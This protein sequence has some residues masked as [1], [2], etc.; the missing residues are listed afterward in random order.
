MVSNDFADS[1]DV[2]V[3]DT[4]RLTTPRGDEVPYGVTGIY[5]S[6]EARGRHRRQ[7]RVAREPAGERRHPFAI[8]TGGE[9]ADPETIKRAPIAAL[10]GFPTAKA[11]T[12]EDFKDEQNHQVD[13]L[14]GLV[15]ALLSLSV[16]V[17]LLGIINTLALS[18]HERTR[19]LGMLRAVGM[20]RRQVRRMVRG[21]SVITAV[22]GAVLGHRARGRVRGD[23]LAPARRRGLRVR[24]SRSG[25]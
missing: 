19:E 11:Q 15:Y 22:I 4:V 21:E 25:R 8:V 20:S 6:A 12:I 18:V 13:S 2:A 9:G 1:K 24:A 7:Q 10:E 3:G 17:A 5:D 23:P 16:I 14:L